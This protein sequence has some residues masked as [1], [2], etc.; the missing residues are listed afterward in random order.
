MHADNSNTR[1]AGF[2]VGV[3]PRVRS[4]GLFVEDHFRNERS[5]SAP[6]IQVPEE[7]NM[8]ERFDASE[9]G[10]EKNPRDPQYF[11][12]TLEMQ[13]NIPGKAPVLRSGN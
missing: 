9:F 4:E 12:A 6:Y 2:T 11:Y 1:D 3:H 8:I 10:L 13:L 7:G 5:C